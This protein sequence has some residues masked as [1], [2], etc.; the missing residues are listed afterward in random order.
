VQ[1]ASIGRGYAW[2]NTGTPES[3][4]EASEFV[5]TLQQRRAFRIAC[6]E[7][8]AFQQGFISATD[9]SA[10]GA[11]LPNAYGRY[12]LDVAGGA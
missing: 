12:L 11:A 9:L 6:P 7:E 10:L 3:L 1:A 2:L 4:M 8:V 5:G